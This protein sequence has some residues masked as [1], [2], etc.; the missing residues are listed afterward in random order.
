MYSKKKGRRKLVSCKN[1]SRP[2]MD[3]KSFMYGGKA[4][5]KVVSNVGYRL[6]S[7]SR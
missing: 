6:V 2:K 7:R 4:R 5:N 1:N 3:S